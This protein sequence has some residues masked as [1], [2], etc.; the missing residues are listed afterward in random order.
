[1]RLDTPPF[2]NR[3]HPF[4]AIARARTIPWLRHLRPVEPRCRCVQTRSRNG[5]RSLFRRTAQSKVLYQRKLPD[6]DWY[7]FR[8]SHRNLADEFMKLKHGDYV[9]W[10]HKRIK[11]REQPCRP[12]QVAG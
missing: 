12:R 8:S 1:T 2:S 5:R 7:V 11:A 10:K 3:H 9:S 6:G 4:S